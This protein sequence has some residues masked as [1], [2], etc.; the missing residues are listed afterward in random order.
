VSL[1]ADIAGKDRL[2]LKPLALPAIAGEGPLF[3][4]RR[5][6][7][8]RFLELGAPAQR[9]ERWKYTSLTPLAKA[10]FALAGQAGVAALPRIDGTVRLVFVNGRFDAARSDALPEGVRTLGALGEADVLARL[11]P[12]AEA[13]DQALAALNTAFST[14]GYVLDLG[15]GAVLERPLHIVHIAG[16]GAVANLRD[17]VRLGAKARATIV[18]SWLGEGEYWAN[19]VTDI[20]LADGAAL[21]H[22]KWQREGEP[23]FH[24]ALTTVSIAENARY[25]ALT[26]A[27]GGRIMRQEFSIALEGEGADCRLSGA[28]LGGKAQHLDFTVTM[29]HRAPHA[30][31]GQAFKSVLASGARSVFQGLV[32]VGRGAIGTDAH[33]TSNN[34]LLDRSAEADAKPE[35]EIF[36]DD[37]ACSHGATVGELDEA[38]VFYLQSRGLGDEA[39]RALLVEGFVAELFDGV[40]DEAIAA[41]LRAGAQAAA[42]RL[43]EKEAV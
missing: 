42:H 10:E 36:A 40:A 30:H 28:A 17:A 21:T 8:A 25:D 27:T 13:P 12:V 16:A 34:L 23:A 38:K 32:K 22:Y 26:L 31:S 4:L 7:A 5:A 6:A 29:D 39:A 33:Q 41:H 15:E 11:G 14:D 1:D 37:V 2:S 3:D 19:P 20:R 43:T 9:L 24:T 35:L 18:E